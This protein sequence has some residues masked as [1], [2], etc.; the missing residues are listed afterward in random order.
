MSDNF[1]ATSEVSLSGSGLAVL[2]R[3]PVGA[4]IVDFREYHSNAETAL[5]INFGVRDVGGSLTVS[6]ILSAGLISTVNQ[7]GAT[8]PYAVGDASTGTSNQYKFLVA[9]PSAGTTTTSMK[10]N[11]T[12]TYTVGQ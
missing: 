12:L 3:I 4:T 7:G 1:V 8:L 6:A 11:Y 10:I 5:T 2:C 9:V